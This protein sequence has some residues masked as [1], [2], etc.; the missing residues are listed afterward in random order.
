VV[1]YGTRPTE[2]QALVALRYNSKTSELK[3]N[4]SLGEN[5]RFPNDVT[6]T[7]NEIANTSD[8]TLL[9]SISVAP[10]KEKGLISRIVEFYNKYNT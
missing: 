5:C 2:S 6:D 3:V 8:W 9:N 4:L 10:E 7:I 1:K